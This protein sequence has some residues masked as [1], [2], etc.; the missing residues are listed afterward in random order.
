[1][2]SMLIDSVELTGETLPYESWDNMPT[3]PIRRRTA[4]QIPQYLDLP[5]E[6]WCHRLAARLDLDFNSVDEAAG[7]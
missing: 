5:K 4:P 1:M 3:V 7:V 2:M 6:H